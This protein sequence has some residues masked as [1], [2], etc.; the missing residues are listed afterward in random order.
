VL[1]V[2]MAIALA[3]TPAAGGRPP[4]LRV[5]GPGGP[6]APMQECGKLYAKAR[7]VA[8]RVDG[9]PE[10]RWWETAEREADVIFESAEYMLSDFMR[11]HP[12]F[13]DPSTRT[14]LFDRPAAIL[15]RKGNPKAVRGL[16]DLARPGM[17]LLDVGGAGQLGLWEDLAG[18]KGLIPAVARNIAATFANTQE[19]IS[20][21]RSDPTLDAWVA[22]ESWHHSLRAETDVVRL[23]EADQLLRGTPAAVA[24]RSEQRRLALDF[25]FFARGEECHAVFRRAGWR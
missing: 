25:L 9:G 20:A 14:S 7:G 22:F 11:R 24:Q 12:G 18:R 23:P 19:A 1:D 13:L 15:V 6:L 8:V 5:Y 4:V 2:L 17:R 21:W 10:Q 16:E 3:S